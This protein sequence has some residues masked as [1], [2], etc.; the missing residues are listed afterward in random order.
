MTK[1]KHKTYG[2]NSCF[3]MVCECLVFKLTFSSVHTDVLRNPNCFIFPNV[4]GYIGRTNK[5][6][7]YR[8][9]L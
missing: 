5:I 7:M 6:E 4:A 3:S 2:Q 8:G 9:L 1:D